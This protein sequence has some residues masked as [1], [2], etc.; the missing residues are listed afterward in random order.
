MCGIDRRFLVLPH[1]IGESAGSICGV[2]R[3]YDY[4]SIIIIKHAVTLQ[5]S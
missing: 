2:H 4:V 3:S 5:L 1:I